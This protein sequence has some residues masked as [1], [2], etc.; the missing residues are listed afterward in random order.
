MKGLTRKYV[1]KNICSTIYIYIYF[2]YTSLLMHR[3][4]SSVMFTLGLR[5]VSGLATSDPFA[6]KTQLTKLHIFHTRQMTAEMVLLLGITF[7][8]WQQPIRAWLLW[9]L[10]KLSFK[11]GWPFCSCFPCRDDVIIR[12]FVPSGM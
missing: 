3:D 8:F 4:G 10:L 1:D 12:L 11:I 7:K 2:Y 5:R 9:W 6:Q